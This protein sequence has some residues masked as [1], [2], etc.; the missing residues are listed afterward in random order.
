M[1]GAFR[2]SVVVF[3]I[4]L[5]TGKGRQPMKRN[6]KKIIENLRGGIATRYDMS[7]GNDTAD[8]EEIFR[9]AKSPNEIPCWAIMSVLYAFDYGYEMGH[10]ATLSGAYD[11][12]RKQKKE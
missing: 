2:Y 5:F 4:H 7:A 6:V 11:K 10:R 3:D 8:M 9:M 1:G 12:G